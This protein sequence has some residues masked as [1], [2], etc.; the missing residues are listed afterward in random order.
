[1]NLNYGSNARNAGGYSVSHIRAT[2]IGQNAK[3][4]IGYAGD[5]NLNESNSLY[6]CLPRDLKNVI[7]AKEVR[8]VTGSNYTSGNYSLNEDITDKIWA[9]S[10]REM[11]GTGQ[12]TGTTTE[13]LGNDG[14]GYTKFSSTDSKYY[15]SSYNSNSATQRAC[16]NESGNTYYWWLRSPY[17]YDTCSANYVN[18]VGRLIGINVYPYY[19][20]GLAFGFCIN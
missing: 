17:L 2:L 12:Y 19:V 8:Y 20:R 3:T 5:V 1:M 10:Q 6:S 15:I 7:T 16:Y 14:H 9:F 18:S 4:N 13:G 11:Y